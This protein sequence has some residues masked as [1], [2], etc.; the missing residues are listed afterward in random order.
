MKNKLF[1]T[2]LLTFIISMKQVQAQL[3]NAGAEVTI[4]P[5]AT[6]TVEGDFLNDIGSNFKNSGTIEIKNQVTNHQV[7]TDDFGGNWVL[8]GSGTQKISGTE[9]IWIFGLNLNNPGGFLLQNSLIINNQV[10]FNN[11]IVTAETPSDVVIFTKPG[12]IGTPLPSD[13]SHINGPVIKEGENQ[14][15]KYPVGNATKYQPIQV[16]F[17][18]GGNE[19]GL[20]A[21]YKVGDAGNASFGGNGSEPTMLNQYNTKEYWDL[22]PVNGGITKGAVTIFWDSYNDGFTETAGLRRVAH[23]SSN[24]SK[25]ENEGTNAGTGSSLAGSV[26]SNIIS[27]WSPFTLGT[28][29]GNPLPISLVNFSAKNMNNTN[30]LNWQTS[31]EI[32]ASHFEIER[33]VNNNS[34]IKIGVVNSVNKVVI[35][36]N[37]YQYIDY[38]PFIGLNYY[39]LKLVDLDGDYRYSKTIALNYDNTTGA[40]GQFYPNPSIGNYSNIDINVK[41]KGEWQINQLDIMGKVLKTEKL[42]LEKGINKVKI[43]NLIKG[44]NLISIENNGNITVRKL[45]N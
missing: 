33:S 6:V 38:Q 37:N 3:Y 10:D 42:I 14:T 34:F 25:W 9:P 21:T 28:V 27:D 26:I 12:Q 44:I 30:L 29:V 31:Q 40:V 20:L 16:A 32:N 7:M 4:Q 23:L 41:E 13:A 22:T 43:S 18:D 1:L 45:L 8:N 36:K 15:F 2:L 24:T 35:E 39:R 17:I 19:L 11:G 5:G